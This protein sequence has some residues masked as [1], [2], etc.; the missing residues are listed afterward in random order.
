[1]ANPA[2]KMLFDDRRQFGDLV[3][4]LLK[5]WIKSTKQ[6]HSVSK[7]MPLSDA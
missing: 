4:D 1:L 3:D 5:E 2:R 6:R 7:R